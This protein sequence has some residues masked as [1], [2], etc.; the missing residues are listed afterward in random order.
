MNGCV[1]HVV[2]VQEVIQNAKLNRQRLHVSWLDLE[3]AFGSVPHA[4]I[5]YVMAYYNIPKQIIAYIIS[6]YTKLKGKVYTK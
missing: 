1:E 6:L 2:V 3:D 5:P 4:L